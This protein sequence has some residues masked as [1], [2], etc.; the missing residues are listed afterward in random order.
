MNKA[1]STT[2]LVGEQQV[3][4]EELCQRPARIPFISDWE[5]KRSEACPHVDSPAPETAYAPLQ[6]MCKLFRNSK[7][8]VVILP[9]L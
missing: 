8:N 5:E 6:A 9:V 2:R 7:R 1:L 4:S 3:R